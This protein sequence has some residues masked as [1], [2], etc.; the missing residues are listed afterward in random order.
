[1]PEQTTPGAERVPVLMVAYEDSADLDINNDG[2]NPTVEN[3]D[4]LIDNGQTYEE[5]RALKRS[6]AEQYDLTIVEPGDSLWREEFSD[7]DSGDVWRVDEL[8]D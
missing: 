1:M 5:I 8:D 4:E 3:H 2:A 6:D 7:L